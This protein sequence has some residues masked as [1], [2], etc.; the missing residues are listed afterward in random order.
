MRSVMG[1]K[2]RDTS[3]LIE[4]ASKDLTYCI[5]CERILN[6]EDNLMTTS[7]RR[8]RVTLEYPLIG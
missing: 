8:D 4:K 3:I 2:R 7:M 1:T 6:N 5:V